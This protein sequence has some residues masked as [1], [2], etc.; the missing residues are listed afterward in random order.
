MTNIYTGTGG[1]HRIGSLSHYTE[2]ETDGTMVMAGDAGVWN[3]IILPIFVTKLGSTAPTWAAFHGNLKQFTFA[4]DDFV[5]GSFEIPHDYKEGTDLDVHV[6]IATN[7]AEAS[8]EARYSFEYWLADMGEA[9]ASTATLTC[10]DYPLTN[11]NGHHE[12]I[13]IGDISGSGVK[14][15]AIV[16]FLFKRVGL[17][18][19]DS[20]S[21]DPFVL[22]VGVHYQID[23]IGSRQETAK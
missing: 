2:F 7:G 1:T 11:A 21:A 19:G 4:I 20:P 8:K 5:Q 9:S 17:A 3:D 16:A 23:T 6:H 14:I 13:D 15:G 22:S 18:D 10:D 12:Y